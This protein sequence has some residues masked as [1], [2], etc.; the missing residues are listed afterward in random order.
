MTLI[1]SGRPSHHT[2]ISLKGSSSVHTWVTGD[3]G[4]KEYLHT[5]QVL[6]TNTHVITPEPIM[7]NIPKVGK[8]FC[9]TLVTFSDKAE[10]L[11]QTFGVFVSHFTLNDYFFGHFV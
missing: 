4:M 2:D 10:V 6:M 9:P 1:M 7:P 5:L 8:N 11:R 3:K